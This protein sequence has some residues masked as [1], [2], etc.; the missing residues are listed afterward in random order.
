MSGLWIDWVRRAFP[1]GESDAQRRRQGDF[2]P[3]DQ[4]LKTA[5]ADA[6]LADMLR[7]RRS[8]RSWRKMRR[9]IFVGLAATT[10]FMYVFFYATALGYKM[11]PRTHTVAVVRIHGEISADSQ[12][13][14]AKVIP[15][16]KRA[17]ELPSVQA[18]ILSIDSPGGQPVEAERIYRAIAEMRKEHPKPVVAAINNMGASAA[19][20]LA[21]HTDEIYAANYSLVGSIGAVIA[22]WDV[23]KAMEKHDIMQHV[24]AS[25]SLKSMLNPFLPPT[26][27]AEKKAQALVDGMA[28]AFKA[29]VILARKG[30]LKPG[31]DYATGEVWNG[32]E[33]KQLGLVDGLGTIEEIASRKWKL[34]TYD[35]GPYPSGIGL[36]FLKNAAESIVESLFG[37]TTFRELSWK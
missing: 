29:D 12:A 15:V 8:E 37:I 10:F 2:L 13:S 25:G 22:G 3:K 34:P 11:L 5:M 20:M 1:L 7:E 14:A 31:V 35:F 32:Y 24:Y 17:F 26:A 16:L 4:E 28:G 6:L 19:Y 9:F 18:I 23:H 33:A 36:P 30:K 27:E 21:V